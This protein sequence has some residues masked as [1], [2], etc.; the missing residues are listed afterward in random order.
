MAGA[1]DQGYSIVVNSLQLRHGACAAAAKQLARRIATTT[2]EAGSLT[3]QAGGMV[4]VGVNLYATPG[5]GSQGLAP[6]HDDHSVFVMQ[7]EGVKRWFVWPDMY[8]AKLPRL[9]DERRAPQLPDWEGDEY[10]L[11]PGDWLYIPRGCPFV[12]L[13]KMKIFQ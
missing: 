8:G 12:F 11:R 13:I 6:H 3:H 10:V 5:G 7:L 9:R 4:H 2:T 1:W